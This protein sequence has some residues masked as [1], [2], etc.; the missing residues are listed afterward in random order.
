MGFNP[1]SRRQQRDETGMRGRFARMSSNELDETS[2]ETHKSM[3]EHEAR[4]NLQVVVLET[5]ICH[6]GLWVIGDFSRHPH[7][8][9]HRTP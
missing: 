6:D 9:I 7:V 2:L 1:G 3:R 5:Y 4:K 8:V